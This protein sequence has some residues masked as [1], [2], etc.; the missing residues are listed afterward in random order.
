MPR[1]P[2][3]AGGWVAVAIRSLFVLLIARLGH[4]QLVEVHQRCD[5]RL[6]STRTV[7]EADET[8]L[9]R[10]GRPLVANRYTTTVTVPRSVLLDAPDGGR[11]LVAAVSKALGIRSMTCGQDHA[12]RNGRGAP[13]PACF[14]G[15]P[16]VPIPWPTDVAPACAQPAGASRVFPGIGVAEPSRP[17]DG[18]PDVGGSPARLRGRPSADEVTGSEGGTRRRRPRRSVRPRG[19]VRPGPTRQQPGV[20]SIDPRGAVTGTLAS[21]PPTPVSTC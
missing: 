15:S 4:V 7:T 13:A 16:Y 8:I 1:P 5:H 17:S 20:V 11:G 14:N 21:V 19:G 2:G 10:Q 12:L 9:D 6:L 3:G 18:R